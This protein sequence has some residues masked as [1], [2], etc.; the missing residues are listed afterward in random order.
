MIDKGADRFNAAFWA[1]CE[2]C[3]IKT[4][5]MLAKLVGTI[6]ISDWNNVLVCSCRRA[7]VVVI[8]YLIANGANNWNQCLTEVCAEDRVDVCNLMIE[9]GAN[10]C[11]HCN[12]HLMNKAPTDDSW[13]C[14]SHDDHGI[15][16]D[17]SFAVSS[18]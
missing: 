18:Q 1:A 13:G 7:S 8:K 2:N 12:W 15:I 4:V 17:N 11:D 10:K 9:H 6:P 16:S 14:V 3:D 5:K